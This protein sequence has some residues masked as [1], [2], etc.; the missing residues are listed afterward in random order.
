MNERQKKEK[1]FWNKLAKGY[2]RQVRGLKYS[3]D[4]AIRKTI[5]N[6]NTTSSA[7]EIGCGTGIISF[8]ISDYINK[9]IAIDISEKMIEVAKNKAVQQNIKNIE[10]KVA[11]AYQLEYQDCSFDIV[12]LFNVLHIVKEPD[13]VLNEVYRVLKPKGVLLTATD[14]YAEPT[15]FSIKIRLTIQKILKLLGII[16]FLS[17]YKKSEIDK[18]LETHHFEIFCNQTPTQA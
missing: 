5:E 2:D 4:F 1:S 6:I 3:Y 12:L 14:C 17:F 18:L 16:S 8:G 13:T 7:L 11:D 15:S 9:I 10:F